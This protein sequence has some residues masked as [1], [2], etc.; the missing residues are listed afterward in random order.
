MTDVER[1]ITDEVTGYLDRIDQEHR[2]SAAAVLIAA[3]PGILA[4]HRRD[5]ID[6]LFTT[7][8]RLGWDARQMGALVAVV[9]YI[10][11]EAVTE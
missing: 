9:S 3:L 1:Y 4:Q 6:Q 5:F 7:A 11:E 8:E 2:I 10:P